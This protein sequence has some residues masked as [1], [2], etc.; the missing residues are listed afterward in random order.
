[1][2]N[3]ISNC[4]WADTKTLAATKKSEMYHSLKD[5]KWVLNAHY[6]HFS[7]GKY[8]LYLIIV[9]SITSKYKNIKTECTLKKK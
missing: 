7:R 6:I 4:I 1:M 2:G 9:I 5:P 8:Y 3:T